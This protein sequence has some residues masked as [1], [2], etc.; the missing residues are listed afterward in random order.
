MN[1]FEKLLLE[2]KNRLENFIHYYL[3]LCHLALK[4]LA[5]IAMLLAPLR[6]GLTTLVRLPYICERK[7]DGENRTH[8]NQEDYRNVRG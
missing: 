3:H 6:R 8:E 1:Q 5:S 7:A 4:G 2:E